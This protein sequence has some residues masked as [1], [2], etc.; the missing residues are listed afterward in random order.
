VVSIRPDNSER[1]VKRRLSST[2]FAGRDAYTAGVAMRVGALVIAGL[3]ATAVL[4]A[5]APAP[6]ATPSPP[7]SP[8]VVVTPGPSPSPSPTTLSGT[9]ALVISGKVKSPCIPPPSGCNYW[10][11]LVLPGG[12][13]IRTPFDLEGGLVNLQPRPGL[14]SSLPWGRYALVFEFGENSDMVSLVPGP[15]GSPMQA[16]PIPEVG[17]TATLVVEEQPQAKVLVTYDGRAC[18]VK[19]S[20]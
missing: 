1:L 13:T 10:A 15:D 14:P 18:N 3:I 7:P 19:I 5:C 9:T 12:D 20:P 17:C 16:P 8:S 2:V 4:S 6:P 11:T